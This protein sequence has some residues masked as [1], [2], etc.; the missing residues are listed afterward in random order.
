[1]GPNPFNPKSKKKKDSRKAELE[2]KARERQ[3]YE[4]RRVADREA[5]WGRPSSARRGE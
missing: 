1:M 3:A 5:I 2:A 4:R